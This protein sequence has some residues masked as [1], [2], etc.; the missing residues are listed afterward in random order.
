MKRSSSWLALLG[1]GAAVAAA[2]AFG[3][4]FT[5]QNPRTKD[6][7]QKLA[8]PPYNPPNAVF[9][10]VWPALYTLM[11]IAVWRI[12]RQPA[13]PQRSAALSLWT[14]QLL[15]NAAWTWLFFGRQ[16][17]KQALVDVIVLEGLIVGFIVTAEPVDPPAAICFL[18]YAGWV[19]FATLL[20]AEIVRLNPTP[21]S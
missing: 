14:A 11:T 18:P 5:P 21:A 19:G 2:A 16:A 6:W 9:P 1:F 3:S 12:S 10:I 17:P 20:N 7:Y 4:R 15:V 8:K 13:S